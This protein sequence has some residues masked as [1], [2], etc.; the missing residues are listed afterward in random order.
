MNSSYDYVIVGAGA[1]GCVLANRLS[2]DPGARVLLLEAGGRDLHPLVKIP[3]GFGM[4]MGTAVN[5]IY[6]TAPQRH[7]AD[8]SMFLPQGKVL[9]GSTS[10]NAMLYV[11]GNRGDYD[12]WRDLGCEGWS[13]E[14]ILPYFTAHESNERLAN[15]FHGVDGELNVADQVQHNPL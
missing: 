4:V 11:R 12:A 15:S 14:D 10:I 2:A 8:R 7:L 5:W 13:Y 9:G 1:A 3:A 6:D